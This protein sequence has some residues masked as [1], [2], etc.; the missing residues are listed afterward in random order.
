MQASLVLLVVENN[1][2]LRKVCGEFHHNFFVN[3]KDTVLTAVPALLYTIQTNLIYVGGWSLRRC[4]CF[5]LRSPAQVSILQH[6]K[7]GGR[8]R[9]HQYLTPYLAS[10]DVP[11]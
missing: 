8:V 1:F 3:W 10:C 11:S 6:I 7:G 4:P 9:I 5:L 2:D